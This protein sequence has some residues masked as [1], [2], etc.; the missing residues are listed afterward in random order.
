MNK[1]T[2]HVGLSLS[3]EQKN[4]PNILHFPLIEIIPVPQ[5][6]LGPVDLSE[7]S[8]IIF[9]SKTAVN[10]WY[11][12]FGADNLQE[13]ILISVGKGTS[14]EIEKKGLHVP[15]TAQEESAEGI[16]KLLEEVCV[17]CD[18]I[19]WPHAE[20]A[21]RVISEYCRKMNIN[22]TE[23]ILY[24]TITKKLESLP[25]LTS[26]EKIYFSSPSSVEAFFALFPNPPS[27]LAFETIGPITLQ[28]LIWSAKALPSHSKLVVENILV[29]N[30]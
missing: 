6:E 30:P 25:D 21:R 29:D 13:K 17:S 12:Y 5:E 8:H 4:D 24:K 22:L 10:L 11:E 2:L 27:H 20:G 1:K 14:R 16:V 23:R 9:T 7:I 15:Y 28:Q 19:F 3:E 26:F 18:K